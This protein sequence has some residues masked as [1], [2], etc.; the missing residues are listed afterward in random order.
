MTMTAAA[1]SLICDEFPAVTVP[2]TENAGFSFASVSM[3]ESCRTP[4]S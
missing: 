2:V 4:S 3:F 1:P